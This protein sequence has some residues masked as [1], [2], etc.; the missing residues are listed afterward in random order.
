MILKNLKSQ[1]D[2]AGLYRDSTVIMFDSDIACYTLGFQVIET[3]IA[4][5]EK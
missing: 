1:Y 4:T 2:T 5:M 3:I